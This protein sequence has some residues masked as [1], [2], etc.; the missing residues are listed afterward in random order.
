MTVKVGLYAIILGGLFLVFNRFS[1][2]GDN[3]SEAIEKAEKIKSN[4][5]EEQLISSLKFLQK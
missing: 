3:F 1:G 4:H 2:G 5:S